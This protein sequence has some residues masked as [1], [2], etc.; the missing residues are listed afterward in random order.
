[1]LRAKAPSQNGKSLIFPLVRST[2][3]WWRTFILVIHI[4]PFITTISY[5]CFAQSISKPD[6]TEAVTLTL[7][8]KTWAEQTLRKLSLEEKVGQM[9]QISYY[10]DYKDFDSREYHLLRD[11]VQKYHVGSVLLF[12]H[13]NEHGQLRGSPAAAAKIANQLQRDSSLPLLMAADIERG[14]ASRLGDVPAF[15]W[16]MAFGAIDDPGLVER[17]AAVTAKEARAVG[18]QWALAPVADVNSNPSNPVINDRSFGEDPARV[19]ALV[20]AYIRGAHENG[21]LATAKHFPGNGDASVDSHYSIASIDGDLE[22]LNKIELPPFVS[23]IDA[24]VD[25]IMLAHARVPSLEPDPEHI[26][27]ISSRIV[28]ETLRGQLAF[29]GIVITDALQMRGLTKIY[30]PQKGSPTSQAA[31][32]AVLAGCD[33]LMLPADLDA[34]FRAIVNSVQNGTIPQSRID[35]SVRRILEMKASVGL[36]KSR[37]VD[38]NQAAT[39]SNEPSDV[40]FAQY[41]ADR[42]ITLVRDNHIVLPLQTNKTPVAAPP[43]RVRIPQ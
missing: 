23:A 12:M 36:H 7:E 3:S 25:S 18:I 27:T 39:V 19:S 29:K 33:V 2:R 24:G 20:A 40:E 34:S 28:N 22:H 35:N 5:S 11:K 17:F 13:F 43:V 4:V 37:F 6:R 10:A 26:A 41:V 31:V 42:A 30:D 16:P 8:G 1:M 15:P 38:Q 14:L 21:L 9:L 32:D